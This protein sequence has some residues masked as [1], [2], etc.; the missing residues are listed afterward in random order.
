MPVFYINHHESSST[1]RA[2]RLE[3]IG[4]KCHQVHPRSLAFRYAVCAI[5]IG[6]KLE[7]LIMFDELINQLLRVIVMHII[8]T[9]TM[10]VQQVPFQILCIGYGRSFNKCIFALLW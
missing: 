9:G 4:V 10:D 8:V 7:L 2:I 5:R 1:R 3:V 6:H